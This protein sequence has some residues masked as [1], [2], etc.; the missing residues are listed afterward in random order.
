MDILLRLSILKIIVPAGSWPMQGNVVSLTQHD[1]YGSHL[2]NYTDMAYIELLAFQREGVGR[3]GG[4]EVG[5]QSVRINC[6]VMFLPLGNK[7]N[8]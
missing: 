5:T 7:K 6:R 3:E 2:Q 4:R 1:Y 8:R